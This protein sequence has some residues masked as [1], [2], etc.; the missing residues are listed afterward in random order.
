MLILHL[1]CA[2]IGSTGKIIDCISNHARKV[3]YESILCTPTITNNNCDIRKYRICF[4]YEQG[5]YRRISRIIGFQYGF[6]PIS[7]LRI[8]LLIKKI[9]PDVVHLHS[10]NCNMV[11]IY[12]LVKFLKKHD[13]PTVVTNHAEFFYTGSCAH[14]YPCDKWMFG[15]DKCDFY[16]KACRSISDTAHLAWNKMKKAFSKFKRLVI[17]SVSPYILQ[18]S[19]KS[20]IFENFRQCLILNGVDEKCF[21]PREINSLRTELSISTST[22]VVVHVTA[23]F[24]PLD[25][26]RKGGLYIVELAKRFLKDDVIFLVIGHQVNKDVE[27]P[28]NIRLFGVVEDQD[29]LAQLYSMADLSV[30]TSSRETF[31]M[32]VAESLLC[33][34]PIVG[35]NAGGPESIAI[36]EY[37]EFVEF[38]KVD[39]LERIIR[40]KWLLFKRYNNSN[41]ISTQ[42]LG[43]YSSNL[44]AEQ[45]LEIY[46]KVIENDEV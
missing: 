10:I 6:A 34:T 28:E 12:C 1:N 22:K 25:A 39:E 3:G 32:P 11:N 35:F 16:S 7:T 23:S 43:K 40:S 44:M 8:I 5:I 41:C 13:I 15:C 27:L 30:I 4:K 24:N 19:Q 29:K 20:P 36:D 38:G 9:K 46:R 17:V 37:T 42:A 14:A 2:D 45:Y 21:Y 18:R 26:S 33:G 31:S